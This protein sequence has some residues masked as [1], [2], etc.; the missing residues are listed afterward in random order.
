MDKR[1]MHQRVASRLVHKAEI[2]YYLGGMVV[3][4]IHPG[5]SLRCNAVM[6]A[7]NLAAVRHLSLA[8]TD[9]DMIAAV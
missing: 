2:E 7:D 3:E 8:L 4:T 6:T 9:P 5:E 1:I